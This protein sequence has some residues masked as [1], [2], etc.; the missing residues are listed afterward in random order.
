MIVSDCFLRAQPFPDEEHFEQEG[1]P[2]QGSRGKTYR[3]RRAF[4]PT[5]LCPNA[6]LASK[7]TR[8]MCIGAE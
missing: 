5:L 1:P 3:L 2:H 4:Y 7:L 8:F 6:F